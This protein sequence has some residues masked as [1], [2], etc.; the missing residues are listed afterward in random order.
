MDGFYLDRPVS[1]LVNISVLLRNLLRG[2][3]PCFVLRIS[4]IYIELE[5]LQR[6]WQWFPY[7]EHVSIICFHVCISFPQGQ[8][9]L[10]KGTVN[11]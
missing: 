8:N 1:F 5:I 9:M 11:Q 6:I 3:M 2:A 4:G 10:S 7:W